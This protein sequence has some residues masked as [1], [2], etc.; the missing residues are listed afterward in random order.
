MTNN[1]MILAMNHADFIIE[2]IYIVDSHNMD[3]EHIYKE[4]YCEKNR[5]GIKIIVEHGE[6]ESGEFIE[7]EF[8]TGTCENIIERLDEIR[9]EIVEKFSR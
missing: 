9:N 1:E 7:T 4:S 3:F 8:K 2:D 5:F 6:D